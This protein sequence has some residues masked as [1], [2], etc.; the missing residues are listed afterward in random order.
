MRAD[1]Q[2]LMGGELG[3]WLNQQSGMR[4]KAKKTAHDRW[5][6]GALIV[7]PLALYWWLMDELSGFK[8]YLV[9]SGAIAAG[10]WGYQPI[11]EARKAI[12]IGINT[13]IANSL[14]LA[15]EH[16]VEPGGEF[17]AAKDY[18]LV[19]H[20]DQS[21]FEDR[22]HGTL[23]GHGFSLYETHLEERRGSGKNRRMV[24]VFRGAI[25][26]MQFGREFRST[27]LLQRAGKHKK[28]FGLGGRK[29]NVSFGGH[30]LDLVDQV[31]PSFENVFDLYSDDQIES[32]VLVHPSYIE[33][34]LAVERA[35]NGDA[36]RALFLR[37]EVI[38]AVE[39]GDLFE[40]GSLD[41]DGDSE[42]AE[43]AARQFEALAKLA[44]AINQN[45]R[46]RV[47][48]QAGPS[49]ARDLGSE[50]VLSP[51]RAAGGG[52]GRRGL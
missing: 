3:S 1:V 19:P 27:T 30:R 22:W 43:E 25:I 7:L 12:K 51:K 23:E 41:A 8:F 29:D 46:G 44:L 14:G 20:Y 39:S 10:W 4:E 35:F 42:R 49:D 36:V 47:V 38:I 33:H 16:D 17:E 21:S 40:S 5:F 9:I 37:G 31:H 52:F 50:S 32:R 13:A 26:N 45:E 48:G 2:G 18:G 28:W 24:T 34:L 11:A 15:Y 6:Y